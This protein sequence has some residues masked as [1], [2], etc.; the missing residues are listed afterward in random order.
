M[1]EDLRELRH[2]QASEAARRIVRLGTHL[3]IALLLIGLALPGLLI[4]SLPGFVIYW[5]L[6]R[7]QRGLPVWLD[8]YGV[9]IGA[10][11]V[12][13]A[14]TIL[15]LVTLWPPTVLHVFVM[16]C[17]MISLAGAIVG[18]RR[19]IQARHP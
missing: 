16:P 1:E 6:R 17:S 11:V 9:W 13:A 5:G 8:P 19:E 7:K 3:G 14:W 4:L 2:D 15:F 12:N 10:V 18:L